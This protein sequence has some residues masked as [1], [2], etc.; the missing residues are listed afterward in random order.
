[1]SDILFLVLSVAA[2]AAFIGMTYLFEAL[3]GVKK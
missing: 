3:R 1:M 2:F